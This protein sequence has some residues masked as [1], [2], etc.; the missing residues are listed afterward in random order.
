[1]KGGENLLSWQLPDETFGNL[2]PPNPSIDGFE[3][4]KL[5]LSP[6]YDALRLIK[7]PS[8]KW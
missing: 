8:G 1:M 4:H 3:L 6:V 2:Y 7:G 5:L